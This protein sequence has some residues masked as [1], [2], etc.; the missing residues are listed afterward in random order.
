M[1]QKWKT[2]NHLYPSASQFKY[3]CCCSGGVVNTLISDYKLPIIV[4][5]TRR[6]AV[7]HRCPAHTHF[8]PLLFCISSVSL[9]FKPSFSQC[10][11]LRPES[12]QNILYFLCIQINLEANFSDSLWECFSL[13]PHSQK[14]SQERSPGL[15]PWVPF[16]ADV[17]RISWGGSVWG[18]RSPC[19]S[20]RSPS[21]CPALSFLPP[22]EAISP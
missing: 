12:R 22:R 1:S 10:K 14:Q 6:R 9:L 21:V 4:D 13:S 8:S 2:Q 5:R 19:S 15:W 3:Q 17:M 20:A 16:M 18:C 7:E 11:S